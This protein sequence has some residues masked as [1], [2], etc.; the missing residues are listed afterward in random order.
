MQGEFQQL[1]AEEKVEFFLKCQELLM[2][3]HPSSPFLCHT[4]NIKERVKHIQ[5][6]VSNYKGYCYKDDTVCALYNKIVVTNPDEPELALRANM[7][8]EPAPNPNAITVDFVVFRDIKDC[9]KFVQLNY[10]HTIQYVLFVRHNKVK[11]YKTLGFVQQI[12][13]MPVM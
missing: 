12:L 8:K 6:F 2:T 10:H 9:A 1:S 5:S 13:N 11:L 4:G 3:H 7:Y